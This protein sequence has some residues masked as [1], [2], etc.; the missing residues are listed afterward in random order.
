MAIWQYDLLF[1]GG[2][3]ARP[4]LTDDGWDI[5]PLSAASTLR[6]QQALVGSMGYPWLMMDDWVVFGSEQGTRIDLN[7]NGSNEV[8]IL[9]RV[10][11]LATEP[12]LD[13]VCAFA[14]ELGGRLFDPRTGAFLQ[15][16]RCSVASALATSRAAAFA[17]SPRSFLSGLETNS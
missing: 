5:P 2:G 4:L 11:A 14:S 13:A 3:D 17:C 6:A 10:D 7:F 8:E 16:D 12:E 9:I 15:P 1:I